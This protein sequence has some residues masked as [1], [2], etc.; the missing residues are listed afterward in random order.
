MIDIITGTY[1]IE[2]SKKGSWGDDGNYNNV[3]EKNFEIDASIQP[4]TGNMLKQLPEHRRNAENILIYSS[5]K[6]FTSDEKNN[7]SADVINYD[8]KRFEVFSVKKWADMTDIPHYE[9]MAT[10]VDGQGG[11]HDE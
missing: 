5:E 1:T 3:I 8:D 2:R 7:K 11:G 10:M 4:L 6:L 9:S